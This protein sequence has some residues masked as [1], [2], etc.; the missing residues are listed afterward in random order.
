MTDTA[1]VSA[2]VDD[3]N[4][5]VP[6][7][8]HLGA[9]LYVEANDAAELG[10]A[11]AELQGVQRCVYLDVEGHRIAG[12]ALEGEVADELAAAS[13]ITFRVPPQV[14]EAW[15]RGAGVAAVVAHSRCSERAELTQEQ[16]SAIVAG[17]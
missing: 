11:L 8:G 16:R 4:T 6:Q 1:D 3:F 9:T 7:T 12:Q 2:R 17:L 15:R 5:F 14:W 10:A 13:F